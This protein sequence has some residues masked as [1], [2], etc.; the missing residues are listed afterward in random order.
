M[1]D[2]E[3]EQF[4]KEIDEKLKQQVEELKTK[5]PMKAK[6]NYKNTFEFC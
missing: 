6:S 3:L 2:E 1:T 5:E 4:A